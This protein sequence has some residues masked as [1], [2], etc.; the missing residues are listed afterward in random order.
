MPERTTAY[1]EELDYRTKECVHCGVE[2]IVG[3]E[4]PPPEADVMENPANA[5]FVCE[6][7]TRVDLRDL[8]HSGDRVMLSF[9]TPPEV[10]GHAVCDDCMKIYYNHLPNDQGTVIEIPG[11]G[12]Q[13]MSG[14]RF[15]GL[16]IFVFVLG[17][18]CGYLISV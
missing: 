16:I 11:I 10:S 9:E 17:F 18:G 1:T 13:L 7:E 3:D 2:L 5:V 15:I 14:R 12:N 8:N 4:T 6:R